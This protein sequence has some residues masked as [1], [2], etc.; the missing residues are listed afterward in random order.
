[1]NCFRKIEDINS[2][3][4]LKIINKYLSKPCLS[5]YGNEKICNKINEIFMKNF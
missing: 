2:E 1:M 3:D 5:I 4:I